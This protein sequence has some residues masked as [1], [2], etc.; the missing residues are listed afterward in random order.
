MLVEEFG[1]AFVYKKEVK[2][3]DRKDKGMID[4]P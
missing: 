1:K 3:E 4:E 2:R